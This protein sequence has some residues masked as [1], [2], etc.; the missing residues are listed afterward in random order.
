[1]K[2][3]SPVRITRFGSAVDTGFVLPW[4]FRRRGLLG[5]GMPAAQPW[6][7]FYCPDKVTKIRH[8]WSRG[9]EPVCRHAY[10]DGASASLTGQ[11]RSDAKDDSAMPRAEVVPASR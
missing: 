9:H 5:L 4:M 7:D 2:G 11:N 1:M 8:G 3:F 6:V 10:W